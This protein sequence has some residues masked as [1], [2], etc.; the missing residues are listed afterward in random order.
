[1]KYRTEYQRVEDRKEFDL[2]DPDYKKKDKP[3]RVSSN[4]IF[5]PIVPVKYCQ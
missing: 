5:V 1:V 2:N 3:A 4:C